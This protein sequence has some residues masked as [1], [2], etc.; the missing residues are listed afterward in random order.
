MSEHSLKLGL[1]I[2]TIY[3]FHISNTSFFAFKGVYIAV[4][5]CGEILF[6]T[7]KILSVRA[8]VYCSS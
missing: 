7:V 2:I 4:E 8:S 5:L 3:S 1:N 6:E